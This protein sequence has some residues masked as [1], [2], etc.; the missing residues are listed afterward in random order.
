MDIFTTGA[1]ALILAVAFLDSVLSIDN[2]LANAA[3]AQELP[4]E[5]RPAAIRL[6]LVLGAAFRII[7]LFLASIIANVAAIRILGACYLL[8]LVWKH[9]WGAPETRTEMRSMGHFHAVVW[10]IGIT[11][12]VFSVDNVVASLGISRDL[13]IVT[14]GVLISIVA[15]MFATQILELLI[16]RYEKLAS[17]AFVIIGLI[18]FSIF[19]GDAYL[20]PGLGSLPH[21]D[22]GSGLKFGIIA[23][24][25]IITI[26]Y[27]EIV[28][29][30][31]RRKSS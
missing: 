12:I 26:G 28:R 27:E 23:S 13:I 5:R 6:G 14:I 1:I 10:Q 21:F 25:V 4:E 3:I 7:A 31:T 30:G 20:I 29:L 11:D 18:A 15:M 22:I 24:L 17:L 16:R 2:A 8:Y 9:F 19:A